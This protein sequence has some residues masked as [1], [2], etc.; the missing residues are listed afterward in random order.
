[1]EYFERVSP[2]AVGIESKGIRHFVADVEKKGIELHSLMVIRRGKCCAAHWWYPYGPE[3]LHPLYSFSK[4]LTATAIGF[5]KQEGLLSLE[6]KLVDIFPEETPENPSAYLRQINLYHLLIMGCGHETEM[7]WDSSRDWIRNFMHHPVLHAPGTFFKYNTMGTNMLGAVLKKKTGQDITE[8]LRPRLLE[9]LGIRHIMCSRME[10]RD[11]VENGGAGMKLATEDMAKF[12]Y[13]LLSR[14]N[15]EGRQLLSEDWFD[16]A[17]SKQI[18]TA[19]DSEGHVKEW[20]NG[21]GYQCWMGTL[22]GSFRADGAYGQ[23]AFVYPSLDMVVVT[24]TATEQTQ[25]LVDSMMEFLLPGVKEGQVPGSPESAALRDGLSG[26]RIHAMMGDKN[27]VMEEK[28][29]G[30]IFETTARSGE[31]GCSPMETL[32]GGAGLFD[33]VEGELQKMSFSFSE[34]SVTWK[35][36]ENGKKKEITASL[37][38][39]FHINT[40][41]GLRYG[42]CARWRSLTALEM[43]IRRLDAISGARLIFRFVKD[44]LTLEADDTLIMA[45]GL[46]MTPRR[47]VAFS[48]R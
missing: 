35:V 19:E 6:E 7:E 36:W 29:N 40:C 23:F 14:G 25:S 26:L 9:P 48:A 32:I 27:P 10:D 39:D 28:L 41:D 13:F 8:F 47:T 30:K 31:E 34:D 38:G 42:A 24:T 46:G 11:Q 45:S 1:M 44:A 33:A 17:C 2:E 22:P 16:R 15:W 4:T 37:A 20:A 18:E 43:E 3:E 5:A 12:G 21:Y